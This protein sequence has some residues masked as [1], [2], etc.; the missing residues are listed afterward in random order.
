MAS[1]LRKHVVTWVTTRDYVTTSAADEAP[2]IEHTCRCGGVRSMESNIATVEATVA[3][4]SVHAKP[5]DTAC[6]V[7][8]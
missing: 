1:D 7:V 2:T 8:K 5:C 3:V 4:G 6:A